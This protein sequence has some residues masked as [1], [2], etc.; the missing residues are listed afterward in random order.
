VLLGHLIKSMC[1]ARTRYNLLEFTCGVRID[2]GLLS[3]AHGWPEP[4]KEGIREGIARMRVASSSVWRL[5]FEG[6]D[7]GRDNNHWWSTAPDGG[8]ATGVYGLKSV[9]VPIGNVQPFEELWD[10]AL[11]ITDLWLTPDRETTVARRYGTLVR[12]RPR[13]TLRPNGLDFIL[14]DWPGGDEHELV[15][16]NELGIVLRL[17]SMWHGQDLAVEEIHELSIEPR[18]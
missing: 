6:H 17:R 16:D 4:S 1:H 2:M 14:L 10:P 7:S 12:G 15:V 18:L 5:N 13:P 3:E 9:D 11:L 8:F